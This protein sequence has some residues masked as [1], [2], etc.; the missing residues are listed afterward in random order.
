MTDTIEKLL[1]E[2]NEIDEASVEK[3]FQ[4]EE[5]SAAQDM[6]KMG[7]FGYLSSACT[8]G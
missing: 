1:N 6:I 3:V 7:P 4:V 8:L 5:E 2:I